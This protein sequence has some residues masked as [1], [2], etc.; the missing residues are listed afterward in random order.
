MPLVVVRRGAARR[1]GVR[2]RAARAS[3]CGQLAAALEP[4][5]LRP[6]LRAAPLAA[7]LRLRDARLELLAPPPAAPGLEPAGA[8]RVS[9]CALDADALLAALAA[10]GLAAR[11]EPAADGTIVHLPRHDTLLHL[12]RHATHVF[13]EGRNAPRKAIRRAIQA[14]LPSL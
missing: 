7:A 1:C 8:P 14:C 11:A 6:G 13:C 2:R 12:E 5:D 3:L 9:C 10:E 4:R